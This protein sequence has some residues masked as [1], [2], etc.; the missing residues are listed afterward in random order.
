[1]CLYGERAVVTPKELGQ[2]RGGFAGNLGCAASDDQAA[3]ETAQAALIECETEKEVAAYIKAAFEEQ[4]GNTWHC[5][6][7]A[8]FGAYVTHQIKTYIYLSV[9]G[10]NVLLWKM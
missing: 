9:A 2:P 8:N 6:V 10:T 4:Y 1:M 7:G 3:C 5:F